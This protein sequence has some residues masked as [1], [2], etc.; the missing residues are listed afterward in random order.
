LSKA[1]GGKLM[2]IKRLINYAILSHHLFYADP[3]LRLWRE[4]KNFQEFSC[5]TWEE[6][7]DKRGEFERRSELGR[8]WQS[9]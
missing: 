1:L 8:S 9:I 4:T 7:T 5:L 3:D 2:A 6:E